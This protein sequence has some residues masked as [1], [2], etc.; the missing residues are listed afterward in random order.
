VAAGPEVLRLEAASTRS[1]LVYAAEQ[2]GS[3]AE[4]RC[5]PQDRAIVVR[6]TR[7][8]PPALGVQGRVLWLEFLERALTRG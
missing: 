7:S 4:V 2:D 6:Y 8:P 3:E 1:F 5:G